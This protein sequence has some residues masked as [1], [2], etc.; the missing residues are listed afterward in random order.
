MGRNDSWI[1][2]LLCAAQESTYTYAVDAS[3]RPL[4]VHP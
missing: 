1:Q 2:T 3:E 4:L